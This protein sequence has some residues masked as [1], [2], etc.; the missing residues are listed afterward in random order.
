MLAKLDACGFR[1]F[2]VTGGIAISLHAPDLKPRAL[3][4]LDLVVESVDALPVG[5]G[6]AFLVRHFHPHVRRGRTLIQLVDEAERLRID[7]FTAYGASMS[8]ATRVSGLAVLSVEDLVARLASIL[9]DLDRGR[10]VDRKYLARFEQ[11]A[12]QVDENIMPI[13]WT[14][15]RKQDDPATFAEAA[16]RLRT[17]AKAHAALLHDPVYATAAGSACLDCAPSQTFKCAP[18]ERFLPILGYC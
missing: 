12:P 7:V 17:A 6:D 15:Q 5:L 2:A 14:E 8:R 11:I 3:W 1:N 9:M 18:P 16:A 4:D 13:A 10:T